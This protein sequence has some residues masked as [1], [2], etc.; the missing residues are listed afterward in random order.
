MKHQR[1][2]K[3]HWNHSHKILLDIKNRQKR[4]CVVRYNT[5]GEYNMEKKNIETF[6]KKYNLNGTIEG[7]V[8]SAVNNNADLSVTAMTSDKKLYTSVQYT[9]AAFFNG[10][11]IGVLDTTKFKKMLSPLSDNIALSLDIDENDKTRVRQIIAE[12]GKISVNY[13]TAGVDAVDGVPSMK[14]IPPFTVE[15]S[16]TPEFI[17]AFS[18]SFSGVDDKD[19]LFT[20]IMSKKK[21]KLEMVLGYKQ[22]NLSDR[23]AL[24]VTATAGKD[25][26]KNPISFN[27]KH[28]KEILAANSEVKD[29]VLNVSELGLAGITFNDGDFK[30]QYYLVKTE[31]ED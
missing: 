18:T 31:V 13:V 22:K 23:I 3:L 14:N 2:L 29:P 6:I 1:N 16:L 15:I 7:V 11:D 12:D 10:V 5:T 4:C 27:A 8:W 25:T 30:S 17:D 24:E 28:L 21:Q 9:K 19:A 26:V 20:L